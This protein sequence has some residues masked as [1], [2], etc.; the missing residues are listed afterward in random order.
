MRLSVRT[1][2]IGILMPLV[3]IGS[4]LGIVTSADTALERIP[5]H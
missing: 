5:V 4:L 1:L 2:L 3:I